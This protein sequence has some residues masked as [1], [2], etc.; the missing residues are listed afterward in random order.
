MVIAVFVGISSRNR[1][2]ESCPPEMKPPQFLFPL[3]NFL[4]TARSAV[5]SPILFFFSSSCA[6]YFVQ[7]LLHVLPVYQWF[8]RRVRREVVPIKPAWNIDYTMALLSLGRRLDQAKCIE[9]NEGER[10]YKILCR[11]IKEE[12]SAI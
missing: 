6:F 9:R 8:Y 4:E 10:T 1:H 3:F 2:P 11:K 12:T 7:Y 5:V